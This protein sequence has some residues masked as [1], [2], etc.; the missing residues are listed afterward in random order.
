MGKILAILFLFSASVSLGQSKKLNSLLNELKH[1]K[2]DTGKVRLLL[3]IE[4]NYFALDLDSSLYYNN[5]CENLILKIGAQDYKHRCYHDFV[6]IYHAKSDYESALDYCLKSITVAKS[7]KDRFQEA[8]SYRAI[9][10]IYHNLNKNDSAVKYALHSMRLTTEIGDTSNVATN[11][12][13]LSWLYMDLDQYDKALQYGL[14]GIEAGEHY[15][16]TVGLLI[17]INNTALCYLR[18]RDIPKAI[19]LFNKQ[20]E[21]GIGVKRARSIRY[22]LVNLGAAYYEI[23]DVAGLERSTAL[24]NNRYRRLGVPK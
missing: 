20:Y 4:R 11:Y 17:S 2:E 19:E 9:F 1:A 13:N 22:A 10:N 24:L 12:G 3:A 5:L 23:G 16:D 15:V 8:T 6:K 7:N 18:T 21:I 14:K